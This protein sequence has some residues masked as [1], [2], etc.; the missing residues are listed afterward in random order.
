[1]NAIGQHSVENATAAIAVAN[2]MMEFKTCAESLKN[3]EE[4]T[5]VIKFW[6]KK[7]GVWVMMIMRTILQ[8]VPLENIKACQP[9][10]EKV[11]GLISA[12]RL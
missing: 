4:F 6:G 10:A 12:S 1:M 8:N 3:Y 5:G 11:S 7:N 9:L 2:Q